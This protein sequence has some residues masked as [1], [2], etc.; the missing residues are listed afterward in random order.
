MRPKC[1]LPPME[2]SFGVIASQLAKCR[3]LAKRW[4]LSLEK[5]GDRIR[6]VRLSGYSPE[7]NPDVKSNALGRERP[8]TRPELIQR[9]RSYLRRQQRQPQMGRQYF[10]EAHVRYAAA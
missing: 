10:D 2:C 3:P 1:R 7:S 6:M 8:A 5:H 4:M 9:V